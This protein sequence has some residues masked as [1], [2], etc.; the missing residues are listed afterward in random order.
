VKLRALGAGLLVLATLAAC[1]STGQGR[2]LVLGDSNT[3]RAYHQIESAI[4]EDGMTPDILGKP[5]YGLKDISFWISEIPNRLSSFPKV[6]VVALGTNDTLTQQTLDAVPKEIDQMMRA[7][8]NRPVVW[9]THTND[10]PASVRGAGTKVNEAIRAAEARWPNLT[11]L[12]L[13]DDI[14]DDPGLLGADRLHYSPRGEKF[15]ADEIAD[16]AADEAG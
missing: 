3:F 13:A 14:E 12:D 10:R 2:V 11:V 8:G 6:V 5:G 16:A 1:D 7:L 9:V 4:R 15:F